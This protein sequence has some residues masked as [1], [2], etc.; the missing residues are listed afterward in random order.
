MERPKAYSYLR[1]STPEQAKGDSFR[2]QTALAQEY[3]VRHGLELADLTFHDL[4][5]SAFRGANAETGR[6]GD[7]KRAVEDE[8]VQPGSYLLVESLDRVSRQA[9]RK[10]R[11]FDRWVRHV[12][13]PTIRKEGAYVAGEENIGKGTE[14][15]D[16]ALILRA[17]QIMERKV[18]RL[19]AERDQ[20]REANIKLVEEILDVTDAKD[21]L[22]ESVGTYLHTVRD[23]VKMLDHRIN[24]GMVS[25]TLVALGY[26]RSPT[27][28]CYRVRRG[29]K[30]EGKFI[31]KLHPERGFCTI[32]ATAEGKEVLARLVKSGSFPRKTRP[33]AAT[34][35]GG[36][37]RLSLS[38]A[39][40]QSRAA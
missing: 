21:A 35:V 28:N 7:F 10:A 38:L 19:K 14:E 36:T 12:V 32:Y 2:R 18:E 13:L 25:R 23:Y 17:M 4:G 20:A 5:V 3:A 27:V 34:A 40:R 31:E 33:P 30:A 24:L 1:F 29:A 26:Y 9:A 39:M 22:K 8:L 16:E 15:D 37:P 6:L 11:E